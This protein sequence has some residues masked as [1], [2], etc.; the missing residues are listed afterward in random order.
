M[1]R[2]ISKRKKPSKDDFQLKER[3]KTESE[4]FDRQTLI[5]LSKIIKKGIL[6]S[7]DYPISTGKEA[8]VFRATT[9]DGTFVAVKI[10]KRE[11]SPFARK[12]EYLYADPRFEK[13]KHN[14]RE[15]VRAFARKEF[16]NLELC[17]KG[18]VHA[19]KPYYLI[20]NVLIMEFLGEGELPYPTLNVIKS[21][22]PEKDLELILGD[23]KKMYK[24]GLVHA[25]LSEYNIIMKEAPYLIDFGQGVITRHPSAN[26]FLERDVIT[27]LKYFGKKGVRKDLAKVLEWIKQS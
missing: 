9:N 5:V 2:S 26:H 14:D 23:V 3:F 20:D 16:K 27:I 6:Q 4:V 25:D 22:N 17:Q 8:N 1:A 19:P 15:I 24:V 21:E 7:V 18:G 10:Y 11:T 13:I 12:D